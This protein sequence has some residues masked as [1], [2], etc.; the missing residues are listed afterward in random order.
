[1]ESAVEE[2]QRK[3][4]DSHNKFLRNSIDSHNKPWSAVLAM[5][6]CIPLIGRLC[7]FQLIRHMLFGNYAHSLHYV[8]GNLSTHMTVL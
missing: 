3:N 5:V 7:L 4:I 8:V 1:M 2:F 6:P